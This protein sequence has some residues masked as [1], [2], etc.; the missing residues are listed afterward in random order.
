VNTYLEFKVGDRVRLTKYGLDNLFSRERDLYKNKEFT[1][2]Q[3]GNSRKYPYVVDFI[4]EGEIAIRADE[5][6]F[7]KGQMR[8]PFK[9]VR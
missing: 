9:G 2:V 5:I 3:V 6:A 4:R 1:V 8:L 7:A